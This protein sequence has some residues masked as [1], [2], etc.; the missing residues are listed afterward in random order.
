MTPT[1]AEYWKYL[2][3]RS[4]ITAGE[5]VVIIDE[6]LALQTENQQLQARLNRLRKRLVCP[7]DEVWTD[8]RVRTCAACATRWPLDESNQKQ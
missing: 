5:V 1:Q 8:T 2:A 3:R 4:D 7:H 6:L